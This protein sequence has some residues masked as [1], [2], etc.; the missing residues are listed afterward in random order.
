MPGL[1]V[2]QAEV[3]EIVK[4]AASAQS[5][6]RRLKD[7]AEE[8]IGYVVQTME[9]GLSA[10]GFGVLNGRYGGA[11]IFGM[12]ADL[13]TAVGLHVVGFLGLGGRFGEHIHNFADG[14]FASFVTTLGRGVGIGMLIESA[15][16]GDADAQRILAESQRALQTPPPAA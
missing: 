8:Q 5:A 2:S 13:A 7:K 12:P 16:A 9:V 1:Q 10:F 11:E 3:Q 6:A 14:A 15:S 4:T